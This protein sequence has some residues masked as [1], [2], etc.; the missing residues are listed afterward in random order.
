MLKVWSI[1]GHFLAVNV[2]SLFKTVMGFLSTTFIKFY[3]LPNVLYF[4]F[5]NWYDN[6]L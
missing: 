3:L 5:G 2:Y 1:K 4:G 6:L